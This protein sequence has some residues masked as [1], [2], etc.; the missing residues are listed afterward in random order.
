MDEVRE[1]KQEIRNG[2]STFF[3]SLA[4]EV[5][6]ANTRVIENRLF[7][8]ANFLESKIVMLYV[9]TENEVATDAIIKRTYDF[10]KIVVLPA[11]DTAKFKMNLMKVDNPDKDLVVGP[12]GILEPNPARCKSVPLDSIDIAIVPGIAMDEKGGRI[13]SGDGYYDRVI[14]DLPMTT[15][16]VGLVFEGQL[17]PQVPMESH[18][19]HVDIIIT[20][21][22]VIYKI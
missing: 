17:I 1:K 20:E 10:N 18:D 13:G 6:E 16:K 5:L 2:I 19:K 21:K 22:R 8:F 11:F 12:R 14:P 7:E 4:S 9:N 3:N 15:R